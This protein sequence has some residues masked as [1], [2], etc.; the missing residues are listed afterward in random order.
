VLVPG[1]ELHYVTGADARL[2]KIV[3]RLIEAARHILDE[4]PEE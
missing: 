4:T 3:A 2:M 1:I